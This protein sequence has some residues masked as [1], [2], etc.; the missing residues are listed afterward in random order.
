MFASIIK[1]VWQCCTA[2]LLI[3]G[4][5]AS[6]EPVVDLSNHGERISVTG[7]SQDQLLAISSASY[8]IWLQAASNS[9]APS[10]PL[11]SVVLSD[12]LIIEPRF[13]LLP[14]RDY[15]LIVGPPSAPLV[16][17]T[18]IS[19]KPN[20]AVPQ[21]DTVSP[22]LDVIPANTLRVYLTFSQPM[23]R[24]QVKDMI[25]LEDETGSRVRSPFLNLATELWDREQKRLTLLLDPGRTKQGVGPN[26]EGGAPLKSG[27]SVTLVIA[28][29]MKSA[30]GASI[31]KPYRHHYS[32]VDALRDSIAPEAWRI[33]AP[34]ASSGEPL[35][36]YFER[37]IDPAVA[38]RLLHVKAADGSKLP[39]YVESSNEVWSFEPY[40]NWRR[41]EYT[42]VVD[43]N[44]ED[45][46]GNTIGYSFDVPPGTRNRNRNNEAALRSFM[47][48][49]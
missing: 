42:L 49:D 31:T 24:G 17:A 18:L 48:R 6:A 19:P 28:A 13:R 1:C 21:I 20:V 47:P 35:L 29:D 30:A 36:V 15:E 8:Q 40:Q 45:I 10:M 27:Q 7:L 5:I 2:A 22:N 25:W 12:R 3:G 38:T 33:A 39:G 23:R 11:E 26:I 32:I 16:A 4:G 14:E 37:A 41:E 46:S 34:K 43:S 9:D 44:L